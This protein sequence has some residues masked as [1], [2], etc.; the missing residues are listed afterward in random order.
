MMALSFVLVLIRL[1]VRLF[2]QTDSKLGIDDYI[3]IFNLFAW[4][5]YSL[6]VLISAIPEGLGKDDWELTVH[7]VVKL[8]LHSFVAQ[9]VYYTVNSSVKLAFLFFYLRIFPDKNIRRLLLGTIALITCYALTFTITGVFLCQP[10]DYFWR[11]WT[12]DT[13]EGK[14]I[15]VLISSY[16]YS[17][18]GIFLDLV[19]MAIPLWQLRKLK[20][21]WKKKVSVGM[22]FSVGSMCVLPPEMCRRKMKKD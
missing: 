18:F 9:L 4:S 16:V 10:V 13:Y 14:C 19:I 11:Q 1:Y 2:I 21:G 22:M 8:S 20:M 3:T 7:N 17:A 15:N 12:D 5:T 6:S